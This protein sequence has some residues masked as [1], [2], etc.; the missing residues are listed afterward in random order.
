MA[1]NIP[2]KEIQKI[3]ASRKRRRSKKGDRKTL[4]RLG[5]DHNEGKNT[6]VFTY[7]I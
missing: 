7:I 4:V 5:K 3:R 6:H 1:E 2:E